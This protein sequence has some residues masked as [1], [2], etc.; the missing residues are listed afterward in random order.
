V[1]RPLGRGPFIA[2]AAGIVAVYVATRTLLAD[3]LPYFVDEGTYAVLSDRA[4][5]SFD[6]LFVGLTIGPRVLNTWLGIPLMELGISP[7]HAMRAISIAAGLG[8]VVFVALVANRVG[9]RVAAL[10]AAIACVALPLLLVH[11]AIGIIEPLLTLVMAAAL[12][13]QIELARKPDLR[14][15][16]ALGVVL[17]AGVLTKETA[18]AAVVLLPV[19]L[20]CFDWSGEGRKGRL[21][22]WLGGAVLALGTALAA[23][24]LMRSSSYWSSYE[25]LRDTPLYTVRSFGDVVD[26]PFAGVDPT[27]EIFG[28]SF[29]GYFTWPLLA[30]VAAGA[31]LG[32]RRRPRLTAVL[33][34]WIALPLA[35]SLLFSTAAYPRHLLPVA[36]PLIVLLSYGF[37]EAGAWARGVLPARAALPALA[38]AAV[39]LWVPALL[40]D[41]RVLDHPATAKYPSRDDW[42]YVTGAP[43]G[44]QWPGV[45][46]G[47]ER[48]AAG[49]RVVVLT[50]TADATIARLLLDDDS[51]YVFVGG[52]SPLASEARLTLTE[53]HPYVLDVAAVQQMQR[54]QPRVIG[55]FHR[56]RGGDVIELSELTPR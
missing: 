34:A 5:G 55:R 4:G 49:K 3:R 37:V 32:L 15:A 26:D 42:Q 18:W 53:E 52:G 29:S 20:L 47:I 27:W 14:L 43:A 54:G 23:E 19:S 31:V 38:A 21:R 51:L 48:Y 6:D 1:R 13:L 35:G 11:D 10:A 44:S 22:V 12:Y 39:L 25:E 8:T 7:L 33:L 56:P 40:L 45:A 24:L 9:G 2:A 50:P 16:V 30:A 17:A 28:P 36:P 46:D 41:A